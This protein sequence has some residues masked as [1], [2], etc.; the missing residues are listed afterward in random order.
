M[1]QASEEPSA[2]VSKDIEPSREF[3]TE[4]LDLLR[5]EADRFKRED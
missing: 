3:G 1:V 5:E 4:Y 2:E